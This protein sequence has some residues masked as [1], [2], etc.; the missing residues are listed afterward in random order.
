MPRFLS[1]RLT[2]ASL[3]LLAIPSSLPQAKPA[4][5][6]SAANLPEGET[7][8]YSIE[9]RMIYAGSA[10]L[11]FQQQ[12]SPGPPIWESNLHLESGG[13]I[14]KLYKIEDNYRVDM[15]DQFCA[16]GSVFDAVEGKRHHETKVTFDRNSRKA[17]YLE[18]DLQKHTVI[19]SADT[20]IPAC[21]SDVIG[22]LYKMRTVHLEPGQSIQV[23]LSDGKKTIS[24]KV[25]AQER[26]EVDT[27]AGKFK[28]IRYEAYIFNGALFKKNARLQF[29]MTDDATRLPVQ[30]RA[31]MPFPIGTITFVLDKDERI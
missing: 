25:E 13:L 11:S 28:T 6:G 30:L 26:E 18:T 14:S 4:V 3:A 1:L 22:A 16:T 23:P 31:R 15:L 8:S 24:A 21:V 17:V 5:A 12:K 19:K 27:K 10:R 29:W 7:L 20:E 2:C 9:W